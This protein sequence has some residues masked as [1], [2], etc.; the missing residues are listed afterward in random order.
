MYI[1][2]NVRGQCVKSS[3]IP[4]VHLS[5]IY[6]TLNRETKLFKILSFLA[7]KKTLKKSNFQKIKKKNR[8]LC[9]LEIEVE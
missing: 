1:Y 6:G 9:F 7:T 4:W 5:S 2:V 8:F 3:N